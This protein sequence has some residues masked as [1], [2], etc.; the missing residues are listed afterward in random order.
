[1]RHPAQRQPRPE[2]EMDGHEGREVEAY[3]RDCVFC[4]C[5]TGAG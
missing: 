2:A 1:M 3:F 4:I 5:T